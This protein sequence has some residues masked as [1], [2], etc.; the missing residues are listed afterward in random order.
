M[1][2]SDFSRINSWE[3]R[4]DVGA[5][6]S[7]SRR[8]KSA[9]AAEYSGAFGTKVRGIRGPYEVPRNNFSH[10]HRVSRER[11]VRGSRTVAPLFALRKSSRVETGTNHPGFF[12]IRSMSHRKSGLS[13]PF[14]TNP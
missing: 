4:K 5:F 13:W 3:R 1:E 9:I 12:A 10:S 11:R 2:D 14:L 7:L 6:C 8:L